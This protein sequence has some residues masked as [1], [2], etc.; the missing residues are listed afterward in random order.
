VPSVV[1]PS[2]S[3]FVLNPAHPDFAHI[4]IGPAVP[5]PFDVRLGRRSRR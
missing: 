5:F 3:N 1:V 4:R 2:E